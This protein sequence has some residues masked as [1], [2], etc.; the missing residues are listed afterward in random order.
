MGINLV[1]VS[2]L[3]QKLVLFTRTNKNS[4][5]EIRPT[6]PAS[7]AIHKYKLNPGGNDLSN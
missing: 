2:F 4:K 6:T 5:K 7:A 3:N 1:W